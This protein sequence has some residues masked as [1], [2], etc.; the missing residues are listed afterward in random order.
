MATVAPFR[1]VVHSKLL[2]GRCIGNNQLTTQWW[3]LKLE[4][5]HVAEARVRFPKQVGRPRRGWAALYRPRPSTEAL[6]P[7]RRVRGHYCA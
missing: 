2:S 3:E 4:C 1:A 5:G 6:P 7:P